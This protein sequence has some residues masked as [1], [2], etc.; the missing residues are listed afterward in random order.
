MMCGFDLGH[1][2]YL[3]YLGCHGYHVYIGGYDLWDAATR[4][5]GA[6]FLVTLGSEVR[7]REVR[8]VWVRLG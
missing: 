8:L 7:L 3:T 5:E 2:C 6:P 1:H 4:L